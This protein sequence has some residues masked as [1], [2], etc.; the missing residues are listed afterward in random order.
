MTG[1]A[2]KEK[3]NILLVDDQPARLLSY[4][5][6]LAELGENL[7]QARSGEEALARVME[8]D[9]A[10]ILLDVNMPGMDGFDTANMIHQHPRFERTPIIFVTAI[11]VTDLDRMR[12]YTL[13]AVDYVFVPVIPEILRGKVA[14][15]VELYRKRIELQRL[16]DSLADTNAALG[17]ANAALAAE[18]AR[19]VDAL[20]RTLESTNRELALSNRSLQAEIA[21]RRRA[22]E[23]LREADQRKDEFLATLAHELRN[24]L[25]PIRSTLDVLRRQAGPSDSAAL[26]VMDRQMRHLVRLIDDLLDVS[27]IT[28][29]KLHMRRERIDLASVVEDAV[30]TVQ[31]LLEESGHRLEV[32]L[33][34]ERVELE[35]DPHRLAQ[36]LA[37]LLNNA[38]KYSEPGTQVRLAVEA[39]PQSLR[40]HVSDEGIG[41]EAGQIEQIFDLFVQV[42]TSLER[43]RGGLGIGLTLVKRLVEMHGGAISVSS[44]GLG[45]GSVFTIELP[46]SDAAVLPPPSASPVQAQ[47]GIDATQRRVLVVDDNRDAA[48]TLAIALQALGHAVHVVCDPLRAVAEAD[49]FRPGV[50]FLDVGMPELNG[51]ELAQLLRQQPWGADLLLVALTGWGQ[52]EDRRRSRQAGFDHH[53]V[54]PAD[55]EEIARVTSSVPPLPDARR[56]T[57]ETAR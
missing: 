47:H 20:N 34:D 12:G 5:A 48:D 25:A 29:G 13:G 35:A 26:V 40:I 43:A 45:R 24:P 19:E 44:G 38:C 15:L 1:A 18:R 57:R 32:Q 11:H 28:R 39:L 22:E 17:R 14:V 46:R 8:Q 50:A 49:A 16:N 55:L 53:L 37:N 4:E 30:E 6:I 23:R 27:R 2:T 21:E 31:S 42:D 52:E 33:P 36:V 51:Y 10:V 41:I 56:G 7:V 54:K 3:V 9:F